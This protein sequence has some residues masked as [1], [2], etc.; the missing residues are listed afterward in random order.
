M[1]RLG[2]VLLASLSTDW[3][4]LAHPDRNTACS[5]IRVSPL[6]GT[7]HV[8]RVQTCC[9]RGRGIGVVANGD[10]VGQG[11]SITCSERPVDAKVLHGYVFGLMGFFAACLYILVIAAGLR[12]LMSRL[13]KSAVAGKQVR[14]PEFGQ[15]AEIGNGSMPTGNRQKVGLDVPSGDR[16][17]FEPTSAAESRGAIDDSSSR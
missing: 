9:T 12:N 2:A 6:N 16:G 15:N 4:A 8:H 3:G 10:G 17:L 5:A 14:N 11:F 13:S 7:F 1:I